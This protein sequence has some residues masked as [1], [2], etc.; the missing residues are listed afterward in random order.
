MKDGFR[1]IDLVSRKCHPHPYLPP[2][3]GKEII[4][5]DIDVGDI[6]DEF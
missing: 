2:S 1:L 4:L 3:R 6:V 5:E